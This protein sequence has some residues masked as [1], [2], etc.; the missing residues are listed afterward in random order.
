MGWILFF[1]KIQLV[2]YVDW[3]L[4][5]DFISFICMIREGANYME[6]K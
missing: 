3:K 6:K 2:W 5:E 4:G 1:W